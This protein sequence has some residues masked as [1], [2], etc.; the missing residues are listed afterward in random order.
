[1]SSIASVPEAEPEPNNVASD[2]EPAPPVLTRPRGSTYQIQRNAFRTLFAL[3]SAD[4]DVDSGLG[5]CDFAPTV[6]LQCLRRNGGWSELNSP[7]GTRG[8]RFVG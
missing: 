7:N 8:T 3:W 6:A 2:P 4:F 1:M 5:P